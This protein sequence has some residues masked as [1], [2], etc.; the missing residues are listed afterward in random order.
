MTPMDGDYAIPVQYLYYGVK[1]SSRVLHR[2]LMEEVFADG[3]N[4]IVMNCEK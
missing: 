2:R 4:A 3:M 1:M